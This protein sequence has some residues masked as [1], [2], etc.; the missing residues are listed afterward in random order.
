MSLSDML[1][2]NS[3]LLQYKGSA[4]GFTSQRRLMLKV[5]SQNRLQITHYYS[6]EL[7][8]L[9]QPMMGFISRD[10]SD[11]AANQTPPKAISALVNDNWLLS[12]LYSIVPFSCC[13]H[14]LNKQYSLR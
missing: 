10:Q 5:E 1:C 13:A 4:S 9:K 12:C 7:R 3:P 8:L 14:Y 6:K 2:Q 11:E